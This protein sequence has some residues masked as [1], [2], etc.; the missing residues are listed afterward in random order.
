M[1]TCDCSVIVFANLCLMIL[2][3]YFVWLV[4]SL[5]EWRSQCHSFAPRGCRTSAARWACKWL[6]PRS[7]TLY[8]KSS[9]YNRPKRGVPWPRPITN[10]KCTHFLEDFIK[11]HLAIPL[12]WEPLQFR[13]SNKNQPQDQQDSTSKSLNKKPNTLWYY[14]CL[15]NLGEWVR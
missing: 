6:A 9:T 14:L 2:W 12:H 13:G 4:E 5:V 7:A 10:E 1:T 3:K 11:E 8:S 15:C